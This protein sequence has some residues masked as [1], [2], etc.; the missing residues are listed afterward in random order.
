MNRE[1]VPPRE[2]RQAQLR[3]A[4]EALV[5]W[6]H[7]RQATWLG[8]QGGMAPASRPPEAIAA[9][10]LPAAVVYGATVDDGSA[11]AEVGSAPV[12]R[13]RIAR[14]AV[15]FE[16]IV[17]WSR[18]LGVGAAVLA[19]LAGLGWV[20]RPYVPYFRKLLV[21]PKTGT[22]VFESAP[23]GSEILVDGSAVGNTPLTTELAPGRHRVEFRRGEATHELEIEVT[24]GRSTT[25]RLDWTAQST[26][27]LA[28]QSEP[29]GARV[30]IDGRARGV[31]P[32]TIN[33]LTVGSHIVVLE[34][35]AGSVRRV[36]T[37][38]PDGTAQVTASI[39]AGWLK[40]LA[41]FELEIAEEK[42]RIRLDEQNQTLLAPGAHDLR[43]ENRALGYRETRRVEIEPGET[44]T[45]S[46]T[47]PRSTLTV[48]ASLPAEV[49]IDGERVGETP[50]TDQPVMIG[51]RDITVR[52]AAG[53][54]RRLTVTV[55]VTPMR[56][57][58]DFSKP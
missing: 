5:A 28:V 23:P 14:P 44:T 56:I 54:E 41:P 26:G 18:R 38:P 22:A 8:W 35:D 13:V 50:L 21:T 16:A 32:L 17:R 45:L 36:A 39:Y 43:L 25:G 29:V 9:P 6:V 46:L 3:V 37:V 4:A 31:T 1:S 52:S 49:L 34:S 27:R 51:T 33:D 48:T 42:G 7:E 19:L 20:A 53:P 24:A 30:L 15:S 47:S 2:V 58:V 55:T 10:P 11:P 57:D 40:V 12:V